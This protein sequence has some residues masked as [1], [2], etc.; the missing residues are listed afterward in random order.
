MRICLLALV[1]G[2]PILLVAQTGQDSTTVD[3]RYLEDQFYAGITYNFM[4]SL[5]NDVSQRN[6]S[7][8]LQSGFIKDIPLNEKRNVGFGIGLGL[9]LNTYYTNIKAIQVGNDIQY[10]LPNDEIDAKR[11]KIET[12]LVEMPL[13]FRWRNSN[14]TEY[15]FWRIYAGIKLSYVLN[16]RSK[17]VGVNLND[18]NSFKDSFNNNDLRKLQYGVT[19][20]FGY[21]NFNMHIYYAL[22]GLLNEGVTF[23]NQEFKITPLRIGFIFY[24]L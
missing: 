9:G 5:P 16:A 23:D 19:F 14:A 11:N 13:E 10:Q 17:F 22:T 3:K 15:S 4:L 1:F 20:N 18:K 24:I 6:F 8:G 21:H 2:I 7:Y 12:H